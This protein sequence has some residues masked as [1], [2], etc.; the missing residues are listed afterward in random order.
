MAAYARGRFGLVEIP[1]S[2][3]GVKDFLHVHANAFAHEAGIH[4]DGLLKSPIT[5]EIMTPQS[6][7][8]KH[9]MLVLGKHSGRHALKQRY[10][11]LGYELNQEELERAYQVKSDFLSNMS[12]ELRTPLNSI[13]GFTSILLSDRGDP[14]TADQKKAMEKVHKNGKHLLQLINDILACYKV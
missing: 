9:S 14:L 11:E 12:H 5:Y 1:F 4:Q 3:A 13:I 8:I 7:G 6:V 2:R 10:T